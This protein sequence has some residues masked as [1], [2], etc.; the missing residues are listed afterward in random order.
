[1]AAE[2]R[3][4]GR[5]GDLR[6]ALAEVADHVRELLRLELEL[7][8]QEAREAVAAVRRGL[9]FLGLSALLSMLALGT[10]LTA[11]VA[12]LATVWPLWLSAGVVG[13]VLAGAGAWLVKAAARQL[14]GESLLPRRTLESIRET[15]QW[16]KART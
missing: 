4:H 13:L 7:A 11:V 10:L 8:K 16:L 6:A 5:G 2:A 15:K 12:A 1:M 9:L 14:R 3:I